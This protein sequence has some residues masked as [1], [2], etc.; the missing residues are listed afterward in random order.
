MRS[1]CTVELIPDDHNRNSLCVF[2]KASLCVCRDTKKMRF[3]CVVCV[4]KENMCLRL[5]ALAEQER[6]VL[7]RR[8]EVGQQRRV[9]AIDSGNEERGAQQG[10]RRKAHE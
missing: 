4:I 9:D 3:S 1:V 7:H 5:V 8:T 6:A 10:H 2:G